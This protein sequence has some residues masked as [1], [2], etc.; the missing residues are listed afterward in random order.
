MNNI[1]ISFGKRIPKMQFQIQKKDTKEYVPAVFS[2]VDCKDE[3]DYNEVKN[4]DRKWTFRNHIAQAIEEK[5]VVQRFFKQKSNK[6]IYE[7]HDEQ[8]QLIGIAQTQTRNGIC[9]IEYIETKPN[10]EYK[11]VGQAMVTAIGRETIARNGYTLTVLTPID[12][13]MPFYI[14]ACGFKRYGEFSLKMNIAQ[15]YKLIKQTELDTQ[16]EI[17]DIKG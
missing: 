7:M 12:E 2:E 3:D 13:A 9:N 14:N 15:I 4:L 8:G 5:D 16:A 17:I 6:S 1:A 11:Y 10:N